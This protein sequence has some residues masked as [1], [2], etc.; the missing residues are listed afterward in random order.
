LFTGIVADVGTLKASRRI[1]AGTRMTLATG[2]DVTD[3]AL[4][5]SIAVNGVCLTVDEIGS[6][7]FSADVS[8]ESLRRSNLGD[9]RP[10]SRVNLE[11][12]L[13]PVDRLGGH[14]VLGHV[15]AVGLLASKRSEGEF[16][17][18]AVSAPKAVSRYLVEKGSV[19]VDG[20][21]LT[22]ASLTGDGFT[23]AAIPHTLERTTLGDKRAGEKVNLE[24][25]VL[26]KYIEKL[27]KGER[28]QGGLTFETLA[29]GG[30]I[31]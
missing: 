15:D 2:L 24:A 26:G 16:V 22:V 4:G 21:S 7:D 5:E 31:R 9:L 3:F 10:G 1:A 18:L 17:V 30:F 13:R 12:A 8:P 27:M 11:R 14:F 28:A 29:E 6:S 25:D 19:A 20:V 23:V